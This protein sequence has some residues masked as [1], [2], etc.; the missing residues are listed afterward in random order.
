M[1]N[2]PIGDFLIQIKNAGLAKRKSVTT[3]TS[4][5]KVAVAR[6]LKSEKI[7][8]DVKIKDNNISVT[9]NF[10]KKEPMLL[11]IKLVSKPGLRIYK[12]VD[13]IATR[14]RRKSTFLII[15]TPSG[16]ISSEEA[17][18][19]KAGGEVIAEVW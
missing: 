13:E 3:E 15:S 10:H 18:K 12:N 1:T 8:D 17:V 4:K 14:K 5:L 7:L 2:Y 11:D 19:I 6:V 9:L 16:V